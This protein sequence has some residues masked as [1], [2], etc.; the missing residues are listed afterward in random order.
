MNEVLKLLGLIDDVPIEVVRPVVA[1][2][3]G[4]VNVVRAG[5]DAQKRFE[6]LAK[7]AEQLKA[8]LDDAKFGR[9]G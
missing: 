1:L 3:G 4:I 2:V 6:A 5:S 9:V 7:T 8:E